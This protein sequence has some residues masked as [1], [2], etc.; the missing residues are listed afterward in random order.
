MEALD[1]LGRLHRPDENVAATQAMRDAPSHVQEL[2]AKLSNLATP[3]MAS[4]PAT[5]SPAE[6][7]QTQEA[8][9]RRENAAKEEN[10]NVDNEKHEENDKEPCDNADE[11]T[12]GQVPDSVQKIAALMEEFRRNAATEVQ[13]ALSQIAITEGTLPVAQSVTATQTA[14]AETQEDRRRKARS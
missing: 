10:P 5:T 9:F 2:V 1:R 12:G 3:S 11:K 6:A 13:S 8:S 7:S 4:E 14:S